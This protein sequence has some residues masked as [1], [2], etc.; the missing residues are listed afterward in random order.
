MAVPRSVSSVE[1][2]KKV[3]NDTMD[4]ILGPLSQIVKERDTLKRTLEEEQA[5]TM[6]L[7]KKFGANS[8]E[9][10]PAFVERLVAEADTLRGLLGD[11]RWKYQEGQAKIKELERIQAGNIAEIN[12]L[13]DLIKQYGLGDGGKTPDPEP[14]KGAPFIQ[15]ER[16]AMNARVFALD[17]NGD[18]WVYGTGHDAL[19]DNKWHKFNSERVE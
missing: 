19:S 2:L 10:F 6:E 17:A 7:R 15:I 18:V 14:P 9:T 4:G 5:G 3:L 11:V 16:D 8:R 12:H 13:R 1:Q